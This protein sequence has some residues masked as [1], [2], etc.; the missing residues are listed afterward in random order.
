MGKFYLTT[1]I[2]Y[3]NARPHLGNVYPTVISDAIARYHR[4]LGDQTYLLTGTDENTQKMVDAA[5]KLDKAPLKFLDDT[6]E[7]FKKT[8]ADLNISFDQYIRTTD[9]KIHWP[10]ATA[11]WKKFVANDDIYKKEYQGLYCIGHEAFITEKDLVDGKCPDHGT[12]PEYLKEENYFFRLSKYRDTIVQK[13]EDDELKI[14][15]QERKNEILSFLREG[16]DDI[17]FS[18]PRRADWP[19]GLGVPV[20]GD[21]SQVM[22]VWCDALANYATAVGYGRDEKMFTTWW[23]ADLHVIGKDLIRFHAAIW[24]AMLLSAGL[25]LPK[26]I[27][28]HGLILSGGRKMSKSL[29]NVV[30]PVE[31]I[32]TYG[33]DAVRYYLLR[34]VTPFSDADM[35]LESFKDAYNGNLANGLGNLVARVMKLAEDN[36]S[37]PVFKKDTE[38]SLEFSALIKVQMDNFEFNAVMDMI[39]ATIRNASDDISKLKI[40]EEGGQIKSVT[41]SNAVSSVMAMDVSIQEE[42]PFQVIKENKEK[43][44]ELIR[45][46]VINLVF[47]AKHLEPFMPQTSKKIIEAVLA[48]KKPESLFARLT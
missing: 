47:V 6:V 28:A 20:P 43:G 9:Q 8:F 46:N 16:L 7:E 3:P 24:P 14:I 10:G 37:E 12:I 15:P 48:N 33:A 39:W 35:T 26:V 31:L 22:Y 34:H 30:D 42:K 1:P 18:R 45:K 4:L 23:P 27:L 17:S 2:F 40:F 36:L 41:V 32:E 29:G 11:F 13:I 21:P 44:L 5:K 19:E 38:F 25:P